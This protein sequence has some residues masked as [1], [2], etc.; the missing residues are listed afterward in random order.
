MQ[1]AEITPW[2]MITDAPLCVPCNKNTLLARVL[3]R[4]AGEEI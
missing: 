3:T 2:P 4:D 1:T